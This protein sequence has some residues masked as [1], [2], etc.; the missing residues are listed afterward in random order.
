MGPIDLSMIAKVLT[1][2]PNL[3]KLSL[4]L[5]EGAKGHKEFYDSIF[6]H[7]S[8]RSLQINFYFDTNDQV[9]EFIE[10]IST[11]NTKITDLGFREHDYRV[12]PAL[13]I[14]ALLKALSETGGNQV[15][16]HLRIGAWN[17]AIRSSLV[18]AMQ[19]GSS[20]L[21]RV[22]I[23]GPK[24]DPIADPKPKKTQKKKRQVVEDE[25]DEDEDYEEEVEEKEEKEVEEMVEEVGCIK[26]VSHE[27]DTIMTTYQLTA[28]ASTTADNAGDKSS[29]SSPMITIKYEERL[30]DDEDED[31]NEGQDEDEEK[32]EDEEDEEDED[33]EDEEDKVEEMVEEVQ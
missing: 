20:A 25:D 21:Q 4:R 33:E 24:D 1:N 9:Q 10:M 30:L 3:T 18:K 26:K 27:L 11:K 28:N 23:K 12:K 22:T 5:S 29:S 13:N 2:N 31:D 32:D 6:A 14:V 17:A 7:P 19:A 8:L 16:T 15:I